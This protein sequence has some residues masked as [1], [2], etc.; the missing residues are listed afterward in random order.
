MKD[1][2]GRLDKRG[3][4]LDRWWGWLGDEEFYGGVWMKTGW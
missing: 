1:L 4:G 2:V 3:L